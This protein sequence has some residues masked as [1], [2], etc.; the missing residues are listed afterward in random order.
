MGA[1]APRDNGGHLTKDAIAARL[2]HFTFVSADRAPLL[3]KTYA[4]RYQVYCRERQLLSA[5]AYPD[6]RES[7]DFDANSLHF[8][9]LDPAGRLVGTVRLVLDTPRGLPLDRFRNG[10]SGPFSPGARHDAGEVSRLAVSL[11]GRT[12]A[13]APVVRGPARSSGAGPAIALGLYRELY[14]HSVRRGLTHLLAAMEAPLARLVTRLGFP[15]RAI[16]PEMD[17]YGLVQPFA[18]DLRELERTLFRRH[19]E[20]Y[21]LFADGLADGLHPRLDDD[22]DGFRQAV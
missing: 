18:L 19:R 7:D 1:G 17:Y 9:A 3:Q 22:G 5:A 20:V 4:L 13:L 8:A 2:S 16:G 14:R 12:D 21:R 15:F 11:P 10:A 6:G